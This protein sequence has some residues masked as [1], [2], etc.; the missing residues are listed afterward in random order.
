MVTPNRAR[1]RT[2]SSRQSKPSNRGSRQE[3]VVALPMKG[4][5]LDGET[6]ESL[7][8]D[9][10]PR[11]IPG[12]V[13]F[14]A[15]R[16]TA[17]GG[18]CSD[19]PHH[20]LATRQRAFPPVLRDATELP[21]LD[22]V[23][24]VMPNAAVDLRILGSTGAGPLRAKCDPGPRGKRR[25]SR[26]HPGRAVCPRDRPEPEHCAARLAGGV[27]PA[28]QRVQPRPRLEPPG[29]LAHIDA[30]KLRD[31]SEHE[32][33]PRSARPNSGGNPSKSNPCSGKSS[34]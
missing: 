21:M 2:E 18:H 16:Q 12:L 7:V 27:R 24:L 11:R 28:A 5:S 31:G 22:L 6:R 19:Q 17:L 26:A 32:G 10:A 14:G 8:G 33:D 23:P 13:E 4:T 30:S 34:G 3:C 9:L 1:F 29:R 25:R 15:G 20:H